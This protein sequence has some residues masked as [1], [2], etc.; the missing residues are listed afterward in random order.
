MYKANPKVNNVN[1]NGPEMLWVAEQ[2][3]IDTR[4]PL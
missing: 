1:N 2:A 3:A 4:L